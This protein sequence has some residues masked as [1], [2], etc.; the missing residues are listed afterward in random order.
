MQKVRV[1]ERHPV[2]WK[3][4]S[5]LKLDE[6]MVKQ[7]KFQVA[8]ILAKYSRSTDRAEQKLR[9]TRLVASLEGQ[10]RKAEA[11]AKQQP[12]FL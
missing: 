1:K 11:F 8:Q 4:T 9:K 10:R 6:F 5:L 7:P 2:N 12:V 3:S